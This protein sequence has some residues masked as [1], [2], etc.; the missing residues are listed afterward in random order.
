M[1]AEVLPEWSLSKASINT[2]GITRLV[3]ALPRY[4]EQAKHM[5]PV[6]CIAD[7]DGRCP[8]DLLSKWMPSE[9]PQRFL[10]R[11]AVSE[12]ESWLLSDREGAARFFGIPP[13]N[14][15]REPD[16]LPDPKREVLRLARLSRVRPIRQEVVSQFDL[17][18]PGAGYN[19]HLCKFVAEHWRGS[20]GR[21]RSASL[22]KAM[23]RLAEFGEQHAPRNAR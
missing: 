7:T 19:T 13:T 20:R 21:A 3:P 12:A 4:F 5:Q 18:K 2:G 14:M 22:D 9:R 8:V 17:N 6:L 10:L 15:P 23:L 16:L 11:L 1:V